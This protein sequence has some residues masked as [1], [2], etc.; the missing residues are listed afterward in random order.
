MFSQMKAGQALNLPSTEN[1]MGK[2]VISTTHPISLLWFNRP[3]MGR[4]F[5][6]WQV[7]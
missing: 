2:A 1:E 6:P 5:Y 3:R 7:A 4:A